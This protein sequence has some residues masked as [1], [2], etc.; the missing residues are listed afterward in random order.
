MIDIE[1]R[2]RLPPPMSAADE[3]AFDQLDATE[4]IQSWAFQAAK[5][6]I[7]YHTVIDWNQPRK[8]FVLHPSAVD[9]AC[10][11]FLYMQMVGGDGEYNIPPDTQMIFDTGTAIHSQLQYYLETRALHHKYEYT[12]EVGFDPSTSFN[13]NELKMAGHADGL[14]RGWPTVD[15][16][17]IW[18]FKSINKAGF[19]RLTSIHSSYIKQVHLYMVGFQAPAAVVVY[20]CKDNSQLNAF[21]QRFDK[22]VWR[23]ML[24]RVLR[25][26][27]QARRM[28]DPER[29]VT[30]ACKRCRFRV[31]C[32][33]DT[34]GL[35]S[36]G[37]FPRRM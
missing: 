26:R 16:P 30:S 11:F 4:V 9:N 3:K 19:Q 25:I 36:R 12:A 17:I 6:R 13:A 37:R 34:S 23:P 31:E 22:N 21:K 15:S 29:R 5:M 27:D 10:D 8:K 14:S 32:D 33:P 2:L 35:T 24:G 7:P 28:E 20:I 18:E 1:K